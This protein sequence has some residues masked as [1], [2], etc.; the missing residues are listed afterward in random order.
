MIQFLF[1]I[2][3]AESVLAALALGALA[4]LGRL[5]ST[6]RDGVASIAI[7]LLLV[8]P[9]FGY[10]LKPRT[11]TGEARIG[12]LVTASPLSDQAQRMRRASPADEREAGATVPLA[13]EDSNPAPRV[14]QAAWLGTK[15]VGSLDLATALCWVWGLGSVVALLRLGSAVRASQR[16]R[17]GASGTP[18]IW[19]SQWLKAKCRRVRLPVPDLQIAERGVAPF[20]LGGGPGAIVLPA[21]VL[22]MLKRRESAAVLVHEMTHLRE[23]HHGRMRLA[24]LLAAAYWWNPLV[25][26][27]RRVVD[28][29][30]EHVCDD[31]AVAFLGDARRYARCL[32]GI[33]ELGLDRRPAWSTGILPIAYGFEQRVRRLLSRKGSAVSGPRSV[34]SKALEASLY[35][36]LAVMFAWQH[37]W[38]PDLAPQDKP[39]SR[40][41]SAPALDDLLPI[42]PGMKWEYRAGARGQR[43][44]EALGTFTVAGSPC[45]ELSISGDSAGWQYLARREDGWHAFTSGGLAERRGVEAQ[46]LHLLLPSPLVLA[47]TWEW[48]EV[49]NVQVSGGHDGTGRELSLD[50]LRTKHSLRVD[51][52]DEVVTVPAGRFACA[53]I[54]DTVT[55]TYYGRGEHL[56]WFS[57]LVGLVREVHRHERWSEDHVI[58]LVKF[59][60]KHAESAG[61]DAEPVLRRVVGSEPELRWFDQEPF[62]RFRNQRFARVGTSLEIWRVSRDAATRFDPA[63]PAA[64]AAATG[65]EVLDPLHFVDVARCCAL[66]VAGSQGEDPRLDRRADGG[67]VEVSLSG[68]LPLSAIAVAS[69]ATWRGEVTVYA[70]RGE[71]RRIDVRPLGAGKGR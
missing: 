19:L 25:H 20:S 57:P 37:S 52:L 2:A 54:R 4:M 51:A 8:V 39:A 53:R 47:R 29:I 36:G 62:R 44:L 60:G 24:A 61:F 40:P 50:D 28:G 17:R 9:P 21:S 34:R 55:G 65:R 64:W 70:E 10:W 22:A 23:G 66:L 41:A 43:T 11:E 45:W 7:G 35:G 32:V 67:E 38:I 69:T 63:S 59:S 6:V 42:A 15:L 31:A 5:D 27:V 1:E 46:D 12:A 48:E 13:K 26:A 3:L 68:G 14:A 49:L 71:I 33:A 30:Q 56:R 58:E 16:L 18:P